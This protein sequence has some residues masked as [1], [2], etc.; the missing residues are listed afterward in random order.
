MLD[1][2][3]TSVGD[4]RPDQLALL[5]TFGT[6]RR[7]E[8]GDVL[9]ADGDESYSFFVVMSGAVDVIGTFDGVEEVIVQHGA[10]R[11]IGELNLLTGQRV[12]LTARV[13]KAGEVIEIEP[14]AF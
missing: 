14:D 7:A 9:F 6:R 2:S 1:S 8:V 11:F 4:L 10:G 5:E 12:Y 3:D 13:A